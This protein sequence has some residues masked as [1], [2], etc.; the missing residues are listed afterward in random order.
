[1]SWVLFDCHS[2]QKFRHT[3][4]VQSRT[5]AC[6][7]RSQIV[8]A[9]PSKHSQALTHHKFEARLELMWRE[10]DTLFQQIE[11]FRRRRLISQEQ[12]SPLKTRIWL[13]VSASKATRLWC[14]L[15]YKHRVPSRMRCIRLLQPN[16]DF[17]TILNFDPA[18]LAVLVQLLTLKGTQ[19]LPID[20]K[21]FWTH[22]VIINLTGRRL[23]S[24]KH[25]F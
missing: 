1:M 15:S 23:E 3:T 25:N 10:I 20:L 14:K 4:Q 12:W 2:P 13:Y 16:H 5:H 24:K 7:C 22:A 18:D 17:H 6:L 19:K 11:A 21:S 9:S 8:L